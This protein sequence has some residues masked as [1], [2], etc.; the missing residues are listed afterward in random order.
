[1]T[2]ADWIGLTL[3]LLTIIGIVGVSVRWVLRH[4][5]KD[6]LAELKPNGGSSLKDQV[7]R[8]EKDFSFMKKSQDETDA[9]R[10]QMNSKIDHMYEIL[11]DYIS[12]SSKK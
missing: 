1:M 12:K 9:L 11:L 4:Y 7:S 6:I 8:L 2:I 3:T 5:I 10:K